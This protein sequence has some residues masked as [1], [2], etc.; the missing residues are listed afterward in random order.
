MQQ[1]SAFSRKQLVFFMNRKDINFIKIV[2]N[3]AAAV[4]LRHVTLNE[5]LIEMANGH[6]RVAHSVDGGRD[7]FGM[8]DGPGAREIIF[9][10]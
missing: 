1:P 4:G 10:L 2:T 9:H 3:L 5:R 6:E 7:P 8:G